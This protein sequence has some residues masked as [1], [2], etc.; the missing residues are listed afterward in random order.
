MILLIDGYNVI[1]RV[2]ELKPSLEGGLE[3]ARMKLALLVSR[4]SQAHPAYD[5]VI[6]FDGDE[7][8]GGAGEQRLAGVRCIFS[9]RAHGGDARIVRFVREYPGGASVITVVSDDN[10]VGNNC[11]AHGAAVEPVA[12]LTARKARP[13]GARAKDRTADGKGLNRRAAAEIDKELKK[14]FGL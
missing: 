11:R 8:S 13:S 3:N 4:W 9:R 12:F 2:P 7:K 5:C 1:H 6:V 10:F 14:K